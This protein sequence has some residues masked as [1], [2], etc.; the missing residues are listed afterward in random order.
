MELFFP[1]G[2]DGMSV[3]RKL[4]STA[5][6]HSPEYRRLVTRLNPLLFALTYLPHHLQSD[7]TNGKLSFSQF[8]LDAARSARRWI[9]NDL[10][11]GELRQAWIAPRGAAKSTWLFLILPLW[12]LAHGHQRFIM[13]FSNASSQAKGHLASVIRELSRNEKLQCDFPE[14]CKPITS[15]AE[16]YLAQTKVN[17]EL[18]EVAF[19]AKG[20]D[21]SSLG[22]KVGN[23]RPTCLLLDDIEPDEANYE[24]TTKANRLSTITNGIFPMALNAV[25]QWAATVTCHGSLAHD[26]VRSATGQG[27][28]DWIKEQNIDVRYYPAIVATEDGR[29]RSLWP[30]RW[31]TR[32]LLSIRK[33]R[34]YQ[35][36]YANNPVSLDGTFWTE[37]MFRVNPKFQIDEGLLQI[38][39][40]VTSRRRSDF[41]GYAVLATN[42]AR[43]KVCVVSARAMR[44]SPR[45]LGLAVAGTLERNKWIT[46]V[47]LEGNQGGD[48]WAEIIRPHLP[49]H[50]KLE[51]FYSTSPKPVRYAQCLD[52]YEAGN[53]EHARE[54]PAFEEQALSYPNVVNDDVLDVVADGVRYYLNPKAASGGTR[55]R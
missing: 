49:A 22:V 1:P 15:N 2:Y 23:M 5:L 11:P 38:D 32:Y 18:Q 31:S 19:A 10:G 55:Q 37:E 28:A 54:L 16:F 52:H 29:P 20:I 39:P 34:Q 9:R 48:T 47:R 46:L 4:N 24:S 12:A 8:H 36:N 33:T 42:A 26:L 50:V 53:V 40:A 25:V 7:D 3:M 21:A 30:Q 51:I 45:N 43:T 14:L 27:T 6:E 44:V 35:L 17:G 13:A 41:T